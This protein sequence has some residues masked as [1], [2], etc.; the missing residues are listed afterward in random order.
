MTPYEALTA[1]D[2]EYITEYIETWGGINTPV[3]LK[4]SLDYILREWNKSKQALFNIF[5]EKLMLEKEIQVEDGDNKKIRE[6]SEYLYSF[7]PGINFI[8]NLRKLFELNDTYF[9]N[10]YATKHAIYN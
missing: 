8:K 9:E 2:K 4:A 5:G 6:V 7:N 1:Q 3:K 10:T